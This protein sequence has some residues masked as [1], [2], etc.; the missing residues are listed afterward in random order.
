LLVP[1]QDADAL[2]KAM[3]ELAQDRPRVESMA[4]ESRRIAEQRYDARKVD[5]AILDALGL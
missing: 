1:V 3:I 2:A 4:A 5:A